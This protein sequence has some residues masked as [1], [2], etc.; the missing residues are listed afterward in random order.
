MTLA[1]I[2][3][4]S[5][6]RSYSDRVIFNENK[7]KFLRIAEYLGELKREDWALISKPG[8]V[9]LTTVERKDLLVKR[10]GAVYARGII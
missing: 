5:R 6:S 10:A 7:S 1:K 3:T 8:S 2:P 9:K 4:D